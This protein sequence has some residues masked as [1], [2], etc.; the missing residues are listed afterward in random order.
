MYCSSATFRYHGEPIMKVFLWSYSSVNFVKEGASMFF[1]KSVVSS[2]KVLLKNH[3][4]KTGSVK[5]IVFSLFER[6]IGV[7]LIFIHHALCM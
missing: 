5:C 7:F 6:F 4:L 2:R 3:I 1:E